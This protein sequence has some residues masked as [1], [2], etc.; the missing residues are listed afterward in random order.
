VLV[1]IDESRKRL[2]HM[3]NDPRVG[4]DVLEESD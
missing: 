3:R 1:D 4:L 2:E